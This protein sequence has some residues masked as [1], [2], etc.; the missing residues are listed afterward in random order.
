MPQPERPLR[1]HGLRILVVEDAPDIL[2]AYTTLLRAD[3]A[4]VSGAATGRQALALCRA[5]PFDV[6]LAD[7]D[8]PDIPGDVLIGA[9]RSECADPAV[10]V[11]TGAPEPAP[12][13]ARAAG[14]R[15]VLTK[16]VEWRAI[17]SSLER[18]GIRAAA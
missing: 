10:I 4:E 14:A 3:G 11:V 2:S 8:L 13:R 9:I 18:L 16:P 1:L 12:T 5:R 17:V 15:L 7:L 6:V